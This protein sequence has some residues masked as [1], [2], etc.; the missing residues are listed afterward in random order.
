MG[1]IK[2]IYARC[3]VCQKQLTLEVPIDIAKDREFYPF[4]YIN[5]HG[6]PEHALML[7]LDQNLAVRDAIAYTDLSIVKKKGR[8]FETLIRMSEIDSQASIYSDPLRLKLYL[9]LTQ[10]PQLE[11]DLLDYLKQFPNF[12]EGEFNMLILP[13]IKTGLVRNLWLKESFGV[14][15]FLEKD[16]SIFRMP[17]KKTIEIFSED[18]KFKPFRESY[19][20]TMN[21][22]LLKYKQRFSSGSDAQIAETQI[23]FEMRTKLEYLKLFN[24][25]RTGPQPL[26]TLLKDANEYNLKEMEKNGFIMYVTIKSEPYVALLA[27]FLVKKFL[28]KYLIE[29]LAQKLEKKEIPREIAATQ[30]QLLFEA[31]SL[32]A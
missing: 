32:K 16:F 18:S 5:I 24:L 2:R 20:K 23:C 4:E 9:K 31:E 6:S 19:L 28:P 15:Y 13:L 22:N 30:L 11:E 17:A 25:L 8:Q 14:C 27:D 29:I 12:V 26:N 1:N 7:F 10:G 21:Q 3:S